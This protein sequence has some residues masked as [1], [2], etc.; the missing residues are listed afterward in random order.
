M[1]EQLVFG[2]RS[3]DEPKNAISN[4]AFTLSLYFIVPSTSF[5]RPRRAHDAVSMFNVIVSAL[6]AVAYKL[7]NHWD[8]RWSNGIVRTEVNLHEHI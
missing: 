4:I 6:P 2:T 3:L 7:Q 8:E 1:V 5:R